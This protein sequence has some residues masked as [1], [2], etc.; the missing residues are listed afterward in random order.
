MVDCG[1]HSSDRRR[2]LEL[3]RKPRDGV[4]LEAESRRKEK[5]QVTLGGTQ[6]NI[7]S[8]GPAE[9]LRQF[10]RDDVG[11]LIRDG[12]G[13]ICRS[14]IYDQD[15]QAR[16]IAGLLQTFSGLLQTF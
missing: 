15:L 7:D 10:Q 12:S 4:G 1:T 16:A 3:I 5:N 13:S 6:T 14:I 9:P 2:R 11:K 8:S